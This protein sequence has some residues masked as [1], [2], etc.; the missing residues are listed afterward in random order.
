MLLVVA[1]LFAGA[2]GRSNPTPGPGPGTVQAPVPGSTTTPHHQHTGPHHHQV[3]A[4]AATTGPG[5]V[6]PPTPI[7]CTSTPDD[8]GDGGCFCSPDMTTPCKTAA[9]CTATGSI[10]AQATPGGTTPVGAGATTASPTPCNADFETTGGKCHCSL[11]PA[12]PCTSVGG[13]C[14]ATT[15][16][17][18][19]QATPGATVTPPGVT[20]GTVAKTDGTGTVHTNTASTGKTPVGKAGF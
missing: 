19:V 8:D 13:E 18:C 15:G 5:T 3:L 9:E 10:C 2:F 6:P 7:P 16:G 17:T 20:D 4:P 1:C 12:T 14:A 11:N